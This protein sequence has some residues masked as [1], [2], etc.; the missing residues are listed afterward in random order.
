MVP[1]VQSIFFS[2][3]CFFFPWSIVPGGKDLQKPQQLLV[4]TPTPLTWMELCWLPCAAASLLVLHCT[5][6]TVSL[7][8]KRSSFFSVCLHF[9]LLGITIIG[10]TPLC[11]FFF[12]F[13]PSCFPRA[14][15]VR[16]GAGELLAGPQAPQK[17]AA[18][19]SQP[20]TQADGVCL[21]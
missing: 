9:I 19:F 8:S 16:A 18:R 10:I 20:C 3:Y 15:A 7:C 4:K 6:G 21:S 11:V 12:F 1:A 14:G 2:C 5:C 13:F 17:A